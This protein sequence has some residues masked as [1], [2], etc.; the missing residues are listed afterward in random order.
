MAKDVG[1]K[2]KTNMTKQMIIKIEQQ[3]LTYLDN[4]QMKQLHTVLSACIQGCM[5][6]KRLSAYDCDSD[7]DSVS[8]QLPCA[9][10]NAWIVTA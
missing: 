2:E 1:T 3:M 8:D 4:N 10:I 6:C 9:S 7:C 5:E